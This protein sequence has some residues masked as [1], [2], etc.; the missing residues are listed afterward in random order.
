MQTCDRCGCSCIVRY[1]NGIRSIC[2]DCYARVY[3]RGKHR[4]QGDVYR[5]RKVVA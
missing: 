4:F 2:P 3:C 1:N 5:P